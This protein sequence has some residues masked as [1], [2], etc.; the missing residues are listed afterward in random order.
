[1]NFN[2]AFGGMTGGAPSS[3]YAVSGG[4]K[5]IAFDP[6]LISC[7]DSC[8][9]IITLESGKVIGSLSQL[10]YQRL[11]HLPKENLHNEL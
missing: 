11:H 2:V 6:R 10:S 9:Q 4:H 1:M 8:Q 3:P 5:I 7:K